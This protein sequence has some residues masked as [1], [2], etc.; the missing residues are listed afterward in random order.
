MPGGFAFRV[1]GR[2][3]VAAF[4][5]L[6]LDVAWVLLWFAAGALAIAA[7]AYLIVLILIG[8]G[9][10]PHALLEPGPATFEFGPVKVVTDQDDTLAPPLAIAAFL[11][12][13]VAVGGSLVIVLRLKRLF[14]SFTSHQPFSAENAVH[15]RVIWITMLVMELSRYVLWMIVKALVAV[16]GLPRGTD[17]HVSSPINWNTWGAILILIVLAEVFR[18]GARLREDQEL[19]I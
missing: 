18:E 5:K 4:L 15:L 1:L 19:T 2:G 11:A 9:T 10:L 7:I 3:S 8:A 17:I 6:A 12:A 13:G 14:K 16:L